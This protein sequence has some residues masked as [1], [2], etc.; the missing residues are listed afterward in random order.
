[1]TYMT[2]FSFK[3]VCCQQGHAIRHQITSAKWI[4]DNKGAL[5]LIEQVKG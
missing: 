1:M 4:V 2:D 5:N 3:A